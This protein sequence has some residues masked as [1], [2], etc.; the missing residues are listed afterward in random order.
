MTRH[1][2]KSSIGYVCR[3]K[4]KAVYVVPMRVSQKHRRAA[5]VLSHELITQLAQPRACIQHDALGSGANL[6]AACVTAEFH[7]IG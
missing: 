4:W 2:A 6:K 1:D 5:N 3:L 7:M